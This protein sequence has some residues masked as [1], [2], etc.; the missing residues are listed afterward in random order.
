[1]AFRRKTKQWKHLH[2]FETLQEISKRQLDMND[3]GKLIFCAWN[4]SLFVY[5]G[6]TVFHLLSMDQ[7]SNLRQNLESLREES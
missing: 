5:A 2:I 7:V 3:E 4:I 1:M 6:L